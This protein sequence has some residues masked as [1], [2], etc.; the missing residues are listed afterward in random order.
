MNPSVKKIETPDYRDNSDEMKAEYDF[1]GGEQ[2]RYAHLFGEVTED[3]SLVAAFWRR[4]GFEPQRF[5]KSE[6]RFAKTPDFK[7]YRDGHLVAF[8]EVKT[9]MRD[10]WLDGMLDK[11][12]PGELVGGLRQDPIY[13]RISN[14][15]H[16]AVRQLESVNP[17]R[18]P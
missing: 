9:L 1:T 13:N 8:C 4:K 6:T 16:T 10:A 5:D 2:G 11:A 15:V 17:Q 7:L 18:K 14:A 12:G 3:E